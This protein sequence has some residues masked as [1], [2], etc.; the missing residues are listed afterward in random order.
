[1]AAE[2]LKLKVINQSG[3]VEWSETIASN[4]AHVGNMIAEGYLS[5]DQREDSLVRLYEGQI[6]AKQRECVEYRDKYL[7]LVRQTGSPTSA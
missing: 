1:M 4:R 6:A 7:S 3:D 5:E 2:H